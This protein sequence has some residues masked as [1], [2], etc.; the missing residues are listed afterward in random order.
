VDTEFEIDFG[1]D[2]PVDL[3][4]T[5]VTVRL[6][7]ETEGNAGG[8]Q[9]YVK[10]GDPYY[11]YQYAE[12]ANLVDLSDWTEISIDLA[13]VA[14]CTTTEVPAEGGAANAGGAP[15]AGGAGGAANAGGAVSAGG[16]G[17]A[18]GAGTVTV[19]E[20]PDNFDKSAVRYVGVAVN[21]GAD[22]EEGDP[23]WADTTVFVDSITF[24]DGATAD[25]DFVED[26]GG[27]AVNEYSEP[28][29]GST[30]TH[31]AC[32]EPPGTGGAGGAEPG[33]GGAGG[34]EPGTGGAGGV[35]PGTGGAGGVAPMGGA[36]GAV[37]TGGGGGAAP[38]GEGWDFEDAAQVDDWGVKN[39]EYCGDTCF[40]ATTLAAGAGVMTAT[41][42]VP[43]EANA[44]IYSTYLETSFDPAQDLSGRTVTVTMSLVDDGFGAA[45]DQ[46]G[47]D[48]YIVLVDSTDYTNYQGEADGGVGE[49]YATDAG[50]DA[51]TF[52]LVVPTAAEGDF[53]PTSVSQINVRID[54]KYWT[55]DPQ[56]VFDYGT[57]VFSIDSVT[58]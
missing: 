22:W 46:G 32:D 58:Y 2:T 35:E 33:T 25:L 18:G 31:V 30:V 20:C 50:G 40:D 5:T 12:W 54:S 38:V 19:T 9:V 17:D 36:A 47:F 39:A 11:A 16:A 41:V 7:A 4:A 44:A 3:S 43:V 57:A 15:V 53:D 48:I 42:E 55:D 52:T 28:I 45:A 51:K 37:G 23:V 10:T 27:F 21:A 34:A 26:A 6:R 1:A 13:A 24:S 14:A 8:L 49:F 56:P 29:E